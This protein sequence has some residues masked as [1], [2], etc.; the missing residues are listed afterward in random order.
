MVVLAQG[1]LE[2]EALERASGLMEQGVVFSDLM[3]PGYFPWR[4]S[5][6]HE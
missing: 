1:A 3:D 6:G 5:S 4:A 2:G